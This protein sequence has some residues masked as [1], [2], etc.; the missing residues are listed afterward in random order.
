MIKNFFRIGGD[1]PLIDLLSIYFL[2][3]PWQHLT[4]FK[5]FQGLEKGCIGNKWINSF[6]KARLFLVHSLSVFRLIRLLYFCE[7][8]IQII[9]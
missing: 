9:G 5:C 3:T 1:E 8:N 4:V 7:Q 6:A 2:S